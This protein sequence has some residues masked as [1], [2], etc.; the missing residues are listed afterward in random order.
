MMSSAVRSAPYLG[1]RAMSTSA[2]D[3]T[4]PS[5]FDSDSAFRKWCDYA[6]KDQPPRLVDYQIKKYLLPFFVA[7]VATPSIHFTAEYGTRRFHDITV[8][9]E[10]ESWVR[11]DNWRSIEGA[12]TPYRY[13]MDNP[14]AQVY[15]G[16]S[17][18][19]HEVEEAIW[20]YNLSKKITP[21]D[22]TEVQSDTI[23]DEFQKSEALSIQTIFS[24]ITEEITYDIKMNVRNRTAAFSVRN[25]SFTLSDQCISLESV[26]LPF[27][28]IQYPNAPARVIPAFARTLAHVSELSDSLYNLK[29]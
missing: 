8:D 3:Y 14:A 7:R 13:T 4:I 29:V 9:G 10:E 24:R 6:L 19:A 22:P 12:I 20:G 26:L 23:I 21:Y 15:V 2:I 16:S 1:I 28:V 25:I 17:L 5:Q 18:P 27:Y 11:N